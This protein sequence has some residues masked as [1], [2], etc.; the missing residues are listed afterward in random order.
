MPP[1]RLELV[2]LAIEQQKPYEGSGKGSCNFTLDV[3]KYPL[4]HALSLVLLF[5]T[6]LCLLENIVHERRCILNVDRSTVYF[7]VISLIDKSMQI[8]SLISL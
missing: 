4:K 2:A 6:T 7:V 8:M 1:C 5:E 3:D